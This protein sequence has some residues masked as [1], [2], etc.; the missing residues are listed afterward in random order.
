MPPDS[1]AGVSPAVM[2][3]SRPRFGEVTIRDRGRLPHWEK[4]GATYFVTFRLAD[5]LPRTVLDRIE[6][7]KRD[8][9]LTANHLDRTLSTSEKKRLTQLTTR[10]IEEYLDA[11]SGDCY[12]KDPAIA[13]IVAGALHYFDSKR[14]TLFAWCIMPNH[15]H[16]VLKVLPGNLLSEILHSWKSFTSKAANKLLK[17]TGHF[18]Q[19]EYYDHL[20]RDN[21]EFERAVSYVLD[22][23]TKAGLKKRT[24]VYLCGQ[25]A[26][27]TAAETA[28]LQSTNVGATVNDR[29]STGKK[30]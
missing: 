9:V 10:R 17:E 11:G 15:V 14:Y 28:A 1:S 12:L 5:S 30:D 20:I 3:A 6:F 29:P 26:P 13:E 18:W 23:P 21:G 22:N 8:I 16:V 27:T 19:R 7:E 24:W 2:G 25:D 4:E